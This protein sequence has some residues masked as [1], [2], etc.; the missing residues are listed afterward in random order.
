MIGTEGA[1]A[2]LKL[3]EVEGNEDVDAEVADKATLLDIDDFIVELDGN[4]PHTNKFAEV[5][6]DNL[7]MHD[8]A[9]GGSPNLESS[10]AIKRMPQ[11]YGTNDSF[12]MIDLTKFEEDEWPMV[13]NGS[14]KQSVTEVAHSPVN[15]IFTLPQIRILASHQAWKGSMTRTQQ[16]LCLI[17]GQYGGAT[18]QLEAVQKAIEENTSTLNR[19]LE[20]LLHLK[21]DYD[22][23]ED[24]PQDA[25][26]H[27]RRLN[28]QIHERFYIRDYNNPLDLSVTEFVRLYRMP[29]R[30]V[31]DLCNTSRPYVA[32]RTSPQQTSLMRKLLITLSFYACGSY[33]RLLGRSIDAAVSQSTVSRIIREITT[34]F[35]HPHILSRFIRFP[36]TQEERAVV[37]QRNE[38]LGMPRVLGVI[39]GTLLRLS[40]LPRN[41]ERQSFYSRK[42]FLSLNNQIICDADLNI[43]NVDARWPGSVTD[44]LIWQASA[45]RDVVEAAY[46]EG[47]CWLL[48]YNGYFTAPWLH[49][50]LLH[51]EPG[52]P[53][54]I[55]TQLNCRCRNVVER[56][57]GVLKSRWRLLCCDRCVN[58]RNATY[59]G[60]I[61]NACCV[62]HN[63]CN[64]RRVDIPAPL[65]ENNDDVEV[66]FEP[67]PE[68][69]VG[70]Q[71]RGMQEM[72][73]L[74][75]YANQRRNDRDDIVH[76]L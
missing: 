3:S 17:I 14:P 70:I 69:P 24:R 44:N 20:T 64:G 18:A 1:L 29:Q 21:I 71:E 23:F 47:R 37:I 46:W 75:N 61:F 16:L 6:D 28:L 45:A 63:Y 35:N 38:R 25:V 66:D 13:L 43:M 62:M 54:F 55:Y 73:F 2:P 27:R 60:Q 7:E 53:E 52:T 5:E 48:G 19:L 74:I 10:M 22:Y 9:L 51:A 39:D 15:S 40:Y 72:Q 41:E 26:E 57:I 68:L 30:D 12:T 11:T 34:A 42:G 67:P 4:S 50:P 8:E 31:T 33:Q 36:L 76:A 59:A 56:C 49:V 65:F 58:Y 32:Q